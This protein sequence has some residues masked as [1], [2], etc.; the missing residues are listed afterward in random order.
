[1]LDW[2]AE[3][4]SAGAKLLCAGERDGRIVRPTVLVDVPPDAKV[5]R[6]EIFGPVA[7]VEPFT[8]FGEA[9][10]RCNRT[11]FG[12]QAG[13]FTSDLS[14]ALRAARELDYG[15]VMVNDAPAFRVDNFPY[16]GTK[17]SGIG[18]EGVRSAMEE[19]SEPRTVVLR[20][21]PGTRRR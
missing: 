14:R 19:L 13:L 5:C 1:M 11:R 7:V 6:E 20:P 8:D 17:D 9:L 12:L 16:G 3:A 10:E 21:A 18:R 4:R 2:I 15:G